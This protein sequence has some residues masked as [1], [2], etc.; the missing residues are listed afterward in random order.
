LREAAHAL[1]PFPLYAL[2]GLTLEN[3][4]EALGA[5]AHGLAAIRLF[6]DATTL[7]ETVRAL[8]T[9]L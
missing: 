1:A 9:R 5:G 7:D 3:A 2:G 6:G 4:R 8:R